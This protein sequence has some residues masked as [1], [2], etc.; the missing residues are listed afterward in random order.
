MFRWRANPDLVY[1]PVKSGSRLESSPI[2]SDSWLEG[3]NFEMATLYTYYV[4]ISLNQESEFQVL[5]KVVVLQVSVR[6][7]GM[8]LAIDVSTSRNK[9]PP[10]LKR[11]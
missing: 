4:N 11:W 9:R 5:F 1:I 2:K 8:V 10:G 3:I 6:A 7:T